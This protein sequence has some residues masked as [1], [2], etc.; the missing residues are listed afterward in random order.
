M[1]R[2]RGSSSEDEQNV[3]D[4]EVEEEDLEG[5]PD[6]DAPEDTEADL[7]S[8]AADYLA[9]N[10]LWLYGPNAQDVLEVLDLLEEIKPSEAS[11]IAEAWQG[12]P[13]ADR[14]AARKAARKIVEGEGQGEGEEGRHVR[15]AREEVGAWL[16]VASGY[17]EYAKTIPDWAK[18]CSLVSEAALDAVTAIILEDLLDEDHYQALISPWNDALDEIEIREEIEAEGGPVDEEEAEEEEE[19]AEAR[20][21]PNG[22]LVLDFLNRLWLLSPEQVTRLV[23]AWENSDQDELELAHEALQELVAEDPQLRKDVRTAQQTISPWLNSGRLVETS[24]FIG[25]TGQGMARGMAGPALADAV[26]AL[27]VGD[28]LAPD[29]AQ[30]LYAPWF[31]LVG[32]PPLP[33]PA[34]DEAEEVGPARGSAAKGPARGSAAKGAAAKTVA[35][36]GA[37]TKGAATKGAA[38]TSAAKAPAAKTSPAKS[39]AAR[40]GAGKASGPVRPAKGRN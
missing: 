32:A 1:F 17:P 6:E 16:T 15:M 24:S 21:G 30:I 4:D 26:A 12:A 38:K 11:A 39:G 33:E 20:Y 35:A 36:K 40:G 25:Q 5:V 10:D 23:S 22:D 3:R 14:E 7:A 19:E 13:R 18:T 28:L 2:R 27:V 37:A 34:E 9:D 31:N 29:D 8:Q